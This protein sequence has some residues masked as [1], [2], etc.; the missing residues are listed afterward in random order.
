MDDPAARRE[1]P[2]RLGQPGHP[3]RARPGAPRAGRPGRPLPGDLP[4]RA[5]AAAALP[6]RRRASGQAHA[7]QGRGAT[8]RVA[9][10]LRAGDAPVS[11]RLGAVSYTH[12]RAHETDS[13]LVCRLL[14][15]K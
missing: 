13:Y 2:D 7:D 14:L 3:A 1:G 10:D 5:Q 15:E 4:V 6:R 8:A 9:P 12:L 11:T